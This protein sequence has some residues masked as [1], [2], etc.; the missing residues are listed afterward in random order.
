VWV[1]VSITALLGAQIELVQKQLSKR[2]P[3][4]AILSMFGVLFILLP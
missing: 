1:P 3:F 4:S 2:I